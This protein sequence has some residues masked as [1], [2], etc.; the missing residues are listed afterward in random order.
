[1]EQQL[2]SSSVID[3]A[4]VGTAGRHLM[5]YYNLNRQLFSQPSGTRLYPQLGDINAQDARGNSAYHGLQAQ[6]ER[7]FSAGLQFRAAYT[8]SHAIDDTNGAFDAVQPQDL[9]NFRLERASS[10]YDTRHR[11]V[12][13]SL[14]ELPFGHGRRFAGQMPALAE[15]VLGGWQV[16]GILVVQTGFPFNVTTPG[17]P[18]GQSPFVRPDVVGSP[19]V[20]PGTP[21]HYFD[22]AAFVAVP[23]SAD[24]VLLRPGTAGRNLLVGP[25]T[26]N[27]DFSLFKD[28]RIERVITQFRAEFFNLTNTPQYGQPQA[29]VGAGDFGTIRTTRLSSERQIQFAL[30]LIW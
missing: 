27:L 28:F 22:T 1:V 11:L 10:S 7:R 2:G 9:N 6:F 4:Y 23:V 19:K 30:R 8:W 16:N 12:I 18:S 25:G 15:Q 20:Y 26:R 17:Q 13:S 29:Q 5:M 24:G 3:I 21:S 14:Y